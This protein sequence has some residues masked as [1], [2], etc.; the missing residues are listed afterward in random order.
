MNLTTP[1]ALT[2]T[3]NITSTAGR[4]QGTTCTNRQFTESLYS[5]ALLYNKHARSLRMSENTGYY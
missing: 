3:E 5:L 2:T 1:V 4:C